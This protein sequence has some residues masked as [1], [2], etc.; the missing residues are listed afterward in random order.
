MRS[1][2][3]SYF[4]LENLL[5]SSQPHKRDIYQMRG[6]TLATPYHRRRKE[7]KF[8]YLIHFKWEGMLSDIGN[9]YQIMKTDFQKRGGIPG[10]NSW[11]RY[12]STKISE[13]KFP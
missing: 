6:F 13:N 5:D 1:N 12:A 9:K 11:I 7:Y 4:E 10:I 2:L 3:T 8:S